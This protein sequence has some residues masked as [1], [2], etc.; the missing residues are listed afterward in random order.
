MPDSGDFKLELREL[1]LDLRLATGRMD[2]MCGGGSDKWG[3]GRQNEAEQSATK[4]MKPETVL[5]CGI[6]TS[7]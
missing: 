3:C 1:E 4:L 5:R 7:C 6:A 2:Q